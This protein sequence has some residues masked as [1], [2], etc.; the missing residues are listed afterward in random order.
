MEI[1]NN[2]ILWLLAIGLAVPNIEAAGRGNGRGGANVAS[3]A[4]APAGRGGGAPSPAK[5]AASAPE[6]PG[7]GTPSPSA[8]STGSA[9]SKGSGK[10]ARRA[11][12]AEADKKVGF[13]E[14][15]KG[16]ER[17]LSPKA[18]VASAAS[19][20]DAAVAAASNLRK[21]S[22]HG[23]LE[24]ELPEF[25]LNLKPSDAAPVAAALTA[26]RVA[27]AAAT[28]PAGGVTA[29]KAAL[30][31]AAQ[32]HAAVASQ[33]SVDGSAAIAAILEPTAAPAPQATAA[34]PK[35][36]VASVQAPFAAV[37]ATPAA[38]APAP[39]SAATATPPAAAPVAVPSP[40]PVVAP[41]SA[42][43]A[44][45][46]VPPAAN[47]SVPPVLSNGQSSATGQNADMSSYAALL[48]QYG[49][50]ATAVPVFAV[51]GWAVQQVNAQQVR[52]GKKLTAAEFAR[53]VATR[54]VTKWDKNPETVVK[55]LAAALFAASCVYTLAK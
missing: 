47:P 11:P 4:P 53:A 36:V 31:P 5:A 22:T 45:A 37:A 20:T 12:G 32:A 51:I 39:A 1:R 17:A 8:A 26:A 28:A 13:A 38:P 14:L 46:V 48:A 30:E 42:T 33:L 50:A 54:L 35:P 25:G 40:A 19:S 52:D 6:T 55:G 44:A 9:D 21:G 41:A 18:V 16:T 34:A 10:A 27:D 43:T 24:S 49:P 3:P 15:D 23:R 7:R 2:V 29:K